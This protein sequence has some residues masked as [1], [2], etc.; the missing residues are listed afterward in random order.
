MK[1]IF[2]AL[3]IAIIALS[4]AACHNDVRKATG[5]YSYKQSG[6]VTFTDDS[7]ESISILTSKQGQMNIMRDKNGESGDIIVTFNEMNGGAYTCTGQIK[8]DSI[9]FDPHE[10]S[11]R[12]SSADSVQELMQLGKVYTVEGTGRGII[13]DENIIMLESWTGHSEDNLQLQM[14]A[15]KIT[16]LAE[17]N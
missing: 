4:F 5:D 10:F 8:G 6:L 7:G 3:L 17:E 11:T 15:D 1:P 13:Q 9:F 14:K 16:L 2:N 12:F